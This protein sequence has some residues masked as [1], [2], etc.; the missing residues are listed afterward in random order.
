M[1]IPFVDLH[2]Q[3]LSIKN[4]IDRAIADVI[5]ETAFIGGKHVQQFEQD[6]AA[7]MNAKHM[8]ACG[9]G[10]DTLE[11]ILKAWGLGPGDEVIVP[12]MTW[13]S[14]SEAV[15][16]IGATPVFADV[17]P[18]CYTI[19]PDEIEKRITPRTKAVI[20]VHLY[21]QCA[22]MPAIMHIAEKHNLKVLE[23]CAQAHGATING[24]KA[25][26]WG[27]AASFSF[28]PGKNL[29][30]YG[31]AGCITTDDDQLAEVCRMIANH[32]QKGK[33]NHI[34]IGRNSR[35]DGLQAAILSVKLPHLDSWNKKRA[36]IGNEF[37]HRIDASKYKLPVPGAG[38]THV[39]HVYSIACVNRDHVMQELEK[40]GIPA[41]LHYPMELP[42]TRVYQS[43]EVF[44]NAHHI[45][46]HHLSIPIFPELTEEQLAHI[47]NVLNS[48]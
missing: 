7:W 37:N 10:T 4:E 34:M 9:N 46:Q 25:G 31:D 18:A 17:D 33:H 47:V 39:Y 14:T 42:A 40:A 30:A 1:K 19:L 41:T 20:P 21:G 2:A 16:N 45:A 43:E 11:I 32:G 6:F 27:H 23:D 29:G 36:A 3:Y 44:P 28:Y 8:I 15:N 24:K 38:R 12:A 35:M 22:D 5:A 48:I 13:I 26:Q